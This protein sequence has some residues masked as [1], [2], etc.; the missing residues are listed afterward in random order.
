MN[1]FYTAESVTEG[2][3]DKLC[4]LIAD[5]VLDECLSHDALSR[6]ACEVLATRG[7]IIVAGEITSLFEPQIPAIARSVLQKVGY[8]PARYAIQCLVHKQS[9]DIA[10]GV[11]CSLERRRNPSEDQ[12]ALQ[13]GAGDQ[14]V[15]VGYAC[16]ETPQ[17]MPLPVVLAHRLTSALTAARKT[18]VIQGLRPDGKA[19]VTM[20]YDEDEKPLRLD[21]VVLSTQHSP[22]KPMDELCWELTDKVLTPALQALPPD[23]DTKILLNPSG[24]FVLG[25]PEADTGLTGRKLMVDSYG[26]FAPHGGGAFS[27][28]DPT[29]MDRSGAY[30]ARYIAKN[31]V[32]AGLCEKCQV[33]LAYAIGK[34]EPVM[35]EVDTFG[36]GTVCAD[37]C[38]AEAVRFVFG[39]TPAEIISQLG[40]LTPRYT[41][42]AAYGHFGRLE[43]PWERTDQAKILRAAV[44]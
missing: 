25:G 3:P 20:E 16:S 31:L 8:D 33:T 34:A 4:D 5:S 44:I 2:H 17:M 36:T 27:G 29:K 13:L 10:A 23:E 22:E 28:K 6:V 11:D 21:T 30:M 14:G 41:Q 43:F 35:V 32:A 18:G 39:L 38:L 19:Q 1:Q 40:L 9:P 37:D 12:P 26:V 42:T 15:M 24:R 7:K